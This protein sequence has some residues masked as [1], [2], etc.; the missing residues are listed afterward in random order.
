MVNPRLG[1]GVKEFKRSK[2]T[3][4]RGTKGAR[5]AWDD[6]AKKTGKKPSDVTSTAHTGKDWVFRVRVS[7]SAK[8]AKKPSPQRKGAPRNR[9]G[10][11]LMKATEN[12]TTKFKYLVR[13]WSPSGKK[14]TIPKGARIEVLKD[15]D[16]DGVVG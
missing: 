9:P 7:R 8:S 1:P 13:M 2:S 10:S 16:F 5:A 14:I 15:T 12:K 4:G 11:V 3:W 6:I